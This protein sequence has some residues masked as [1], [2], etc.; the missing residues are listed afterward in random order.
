MQKL[1]LTRITAIVIGVVISFVVIAAGLFTYFSVFSRAS[2]AAPS[3][4]L[5]TKITSQ[6]AVITWSTGEETQGTIEYGTSPAELGFYAPEAL[7]TTTHS[8]DLTLL[9]P[10]TTHYFIIRVGDNVFDN[11]GIPW[12]FTTKPVDGEEDQE[13]TE[14]AN[15]DDG[16][17]P[18]VTPEEEPT[19]SNDDET[20][21]TPTRTVSRAVSRVP[22]SRPNTPTSRV[23]TPTKTPIPTRISC[24]STNCDA[25]AGYLGPGKCTVQDYYKCLY[26]KITPTVTPSISVTP[27]ASPTVSLQ[28]PSDVRANTD[29]A[30]QITVTFWDKNGNE[31]GYEV[32]RATFSASLDWDV[33]KTFSGISGSDSKV[34]Y[35]DSGLASAT[36][37]YY[38]VRAFIVGGSYSNYGPSNN[39][40]EAAKATTQ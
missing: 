40:A 22:T 21:T 31:S 30:S 39:E 17:S 13:A 27:S 14:E 8:V 36:T 4:V 24:T 28:T 33:V 32:Q 26:K 12:T 10:N 37:Y 16:D 6:S 15:L 11:A 3:D 2:N 7:K 19:P 34:T 38:R 9:Q 23:N 18:Q 20:G 29:S 25:I 1:K 5:V 35:I